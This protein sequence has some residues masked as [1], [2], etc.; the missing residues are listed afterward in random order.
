M[1][2]D[3]TSLDEQA[4]P[5]WLA[6]SVGG[7]L[8]AVARYGVAE[9][10]DRSE[11]GAFPWDTLS[12]N[13]VGSFL[14]ALLVTLAGSSARWTTIRL[15]FGTGLLGAF[16]TFSTFSVDTANLLRDGAWL[17]ATLYVLV[18]LAGG[19]ILAIAGVGLGHRW[20]AR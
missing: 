11:P 2:D 19:L 13:L 7:A 8:G 16:T 14:L 20:R 12:V 9:L 18:S 15:F 10:I 6:V 4:L 5:P 1:S 17:T 3:A